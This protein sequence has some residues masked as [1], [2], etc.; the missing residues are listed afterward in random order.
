MTLTDGLDARRAAPRDQNSVPQ[1]EHRARPSSDQFEFALIAD[2]TQ[3]AALE[4]D[5]NDLFARAGRPHQLFQ[6]YDWLR[7]WANHYLDDRTTLSI[8]VGRQGG[9]LV[10]IWPL[11]AIRRALAQP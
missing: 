2:Q 4:P 7:H 1:P 9:R 6:A 8:V 10:M 5:W 11:V 3:F